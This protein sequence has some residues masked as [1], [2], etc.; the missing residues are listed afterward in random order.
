MR[1]EECVSILRTCAGHSVPRSNM[2]ETSPEMRKHQGRNLETTTLQCCLF[3]CSYS[4]PHRDF[5][6]H[7]HR[8]VNTSVQRN[9]QT[10]LF[11]TCIDEHLAPAAM[12]CAKVKS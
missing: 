11:S 4:V 12:K 10:L 2:N 6:E 7:L 3:L 5:Y 9:L 8:Q 1:G